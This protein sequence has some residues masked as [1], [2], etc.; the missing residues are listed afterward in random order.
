MLKVKNDFLLSLTL[1]TFTGTVSVV[2][3]KIVSGKSTVTL[4][5]LFSIF[6]TTG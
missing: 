6:G 5:W 1:S 4:I 3:G 2:L